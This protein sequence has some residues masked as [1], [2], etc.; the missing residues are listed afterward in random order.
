M[1]LLRNLK[2]I[3]LVSD[4]KKKLMVTLGIIAVYRFGAH[5]PIPGIDGQALSNLFQSGAM[6]GGLFSYFNLF[7]GGA[8]QRFAIFALGMSPYIQA[9]IMMQLLTIMLPSLE[10]LSKEGAYGRQIV[11]QYQRYL[12]LGIGVIQAFTAAAV[13]E[14]QPG[15]VLNPGWEFKLTAVLILS[16]GSL[17]TMWLGEQI[18]ARGLGNG[19]SVLIFAGIVAS[20][21]NALLTLWESLRLGQ[22]DL[23][24]VLLLCAIA[25]AVVG[26]IVSLERGE[27]KIPVQ[28]AKRVVGQKVYGG[29]SSYIP[30]KINPSGVVPV[31][32]S[33]A[34]M[35]MP[36]TIAGDRKSVV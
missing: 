12:A 11:N 14:R 19:S 7:S 3:F 2:N 30:L 8:L 5:V 18:N 36:L 23:I 1:V 35:A 26:C 13:I 28:Y 24:M 16:V 10:A 29:Q 21:P 33:S 32:F 22:I 27:R 31:I 6:S 25:L 20:L 34:I 9:S 15:I 4:L 17:L